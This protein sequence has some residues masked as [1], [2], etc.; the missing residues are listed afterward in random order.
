[1]HTCI[2]CNTEFSPKRNTRNKYCD[3]QC[4]QDYTF[5]IKFV[6]FIGGENNIF[7]H[8]RSKKKALIHRD[9]YICSVCKISEW[10]G[11]ELC[12]EIDHID[13][14]YTNNTSSNLRLICPNCHSQT[15]T[16]RA[17]NKGNGR[18]FRRKQAQIE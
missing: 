17:K 9:G 12:L 13:G 18:E 10:N 4:Q 5:K 14:N 7:I 2:N 15:P 11:K 3:N 8:P 1:M 16:F 6:A